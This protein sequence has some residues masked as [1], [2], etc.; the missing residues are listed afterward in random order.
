MYLLLHEPHVL[1]LREV[2]HALVAQNHRDAPLPVLE[3]KLLEHG[4]IAVVKVDHAAGHH[5]RAI[6][7]SEALVALTNRSLSRLC[8]T[9][10]Q[11]AVAGAGKSG[12]LSNSR[13]ESLY[14]Y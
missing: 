11:V 3:P 10:F 2:A 6:P 8:G 1:A 4:G 7:T 13:R 12:S 14:D 9:V 5:F